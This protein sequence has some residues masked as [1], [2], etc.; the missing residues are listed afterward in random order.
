MTTNGSTPLQDAL[1]DSLPY[2]DNDLETHPG[3][4]AKVDAELAKE[5][6]SLPPPDPTTDPRL[7]PERPLFKNNPL[8]AAE[9]ERVKAKL[10]LAALD[11][12]RYKLPAPPPDSAT[13]ADW[14][15][16]I[17]NAKAQLEH[18]RTRQVN[19]SLLQTYGS[20]AWR[21]H[22]Y[23]TEA[24]AVQYEKAL[25]RLQDQVTEVNRNRKN[26]QTMAGNQ[27][28]SLE[29]RWT[30]LISAVLQ[31]ELANVAMEGEIEELRR[32]DADLGNV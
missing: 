32:K 13:E 26:T 8:L 28:T 14:K 19:L 20:N 31:L 27:L 1:I 7:L 9:F 11:T 5:L 10:P 24:A 12:S 29:K 15:A 16:A 2:F 6:T 21:V 25:E 3:L 30:E 22:N 17:D 18:Q 23:L 4:Q